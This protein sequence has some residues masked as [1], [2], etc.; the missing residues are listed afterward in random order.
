MKPCSRSGARTQLSVN[1]NHRKHKN[2]SWSTQTTV[3]V[4]TGPSSE[5]ASWSILSHIRAS[6][7]VGLQFQLLP[8]AS[9]VHEAQEA[10][11]MVPRFP[12]LPHPLGAL[13]PSFR[14]PKSLASF[15]HPWHPPPQELQA[16]EK[17]WMQ[18]CHL[19]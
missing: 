1:I 2:N 19:T 14:L 5:D 3:C 7:W 18:A 16:T 17:K 15:C 6:A 13:R 11:G 9:S 12:I 10:A 4:G 8:S